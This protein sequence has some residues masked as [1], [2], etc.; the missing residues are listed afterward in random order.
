MTLITE[1]VYRKLTG[2][3]RTPTSEV[4]AALA[5]AQSLVEMRL[6]RGLSLAD[7]TET[8]TVFP[9]SYV[10][11]A[12][13]PVAAAT[14]GYVN[15]ATI[16]VSSGDYVF[17]GYPYSVP[18]GYNTHPRATVTYT[19]GYS[20]ATLPEPLALGISMVARALTNPQ[21]GMFMAG[22]KSYSEGD[23]SATFETAPDSSWPAGVW[24]LIRR[25]ARRDVAAA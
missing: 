2:D 17:N 12:V 10:Y 8:L 21:T 11:P 15:S 1:Q 4:V 20:A 6:G 22:I 25:W 23:I 24:S 7:Y 19:G 18:F 14:S 5:V 9:Q 13:T 16:S 3:L